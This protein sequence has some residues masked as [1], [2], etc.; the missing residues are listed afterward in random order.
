VRAE[1][2]FDLFDV[3]FTEERSLIAEEGIQLLCRKWQE[4]GV[5]HVKRVDGFESGEDC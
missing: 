1:R 4:W 5:Q 3:L 2:V